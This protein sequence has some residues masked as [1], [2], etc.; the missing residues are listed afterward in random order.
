VLAVQNE[1]AVPAVAEIPT[2]GIEA[3]SIEVEGYA[4]E[5]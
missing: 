2:P 3:P 4:I 5:M 1:F